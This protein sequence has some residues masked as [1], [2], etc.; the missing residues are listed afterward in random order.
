[1]SDYH[2]LT[3]SDDGNTLRIVAHFPVPDTNNDIGVNYRTALIQMLGGS[4][5]SAVPF[6]EQIEQD[7]LDAGELYEYSA[8][9]NT[10]PGETKL[11]KQDRL[12]ALYVTKQADVLAAL[13]FRLSYWGHSRDVPE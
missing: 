12:D 6:I 5:T 10:W 2:I 11:Q 7:A 3:A 8:T 9:F 1:M 4:Q 13:S